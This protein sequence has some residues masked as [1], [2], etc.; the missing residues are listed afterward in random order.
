MIV[1]QNQTN[2]QIEKTRAPKKNSGI[3]GDL[4]KSPLFRDRGVFA[5]FD[6][7]F[8]GGP[9]KRTGFKLSIWMWMKI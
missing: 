1:D 6:L 2:T 7:G 3:S 5:D 9:Q 4:A 8:L